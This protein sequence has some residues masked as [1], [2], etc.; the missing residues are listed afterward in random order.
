[1]MMSEGKF[2][3]VG[4]GEVFYSYRFWFYGSTLLFTLIRKK[5]I[6]YIK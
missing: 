2:L 1:M 5:K 6:K 4:V 3:A